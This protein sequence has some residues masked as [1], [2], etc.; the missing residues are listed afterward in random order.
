MLSEVLHASRVQISSSIHQH[1]RLIQSHSRSSMLLVTA[2]RATIHRIKVLGLHCEIRHPSYNIFNVT[3]I[4]KW[5]RRDVC[6]NREEYHQIMLTIRR[7]NL[8]CVVRNTPL[9]N[10]NGLQ[11]QRLMV[12]R[13]RML[14]D[15]NRRKPENNSAKCYFRTRRLQKKTQVLLLSKHNSDVTL[16]C[17]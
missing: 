16:T 15:K 13:T 7:R 6:P 1:M 11:L 14:I 12:R 9:D 17:Y 5:S 10:A 3:Q 8:H 4:Y 2:E